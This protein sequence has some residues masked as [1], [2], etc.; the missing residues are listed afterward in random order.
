MLNLWA[1]VNIYFSQAWED[2]RTE[3]LLIFSALFI[4]IVGQCLRGKFKT[5][6]MR[7]KFERERANAK[8]RAGMSRICDSRRSGKSWMSL[9]SSI[10]KEREMTGGENQKSIRFTLAPPGHCWH[11]C[12]ATRIPIL[13]KVQRTTRV[14]DVCGTSDTI[15]NTV[16]N[17][18]FMADGGWGEVS[19]LILGIASE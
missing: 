12:L 16:W 8:S 19:A 14:R 13:S 17:Q 6:K 9:E 3:G 1:H 4:F 11:L 7:E 18:T 5:R 2:E 10:G 15:K